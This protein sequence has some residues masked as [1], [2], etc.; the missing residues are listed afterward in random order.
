MSLYNI[1]SGWYTALTKE[2][3]I[4]QL[5]LSQQAHATLASYAAPM[6]EGVIKTPPE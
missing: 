3:F 1:L 4:V 6:V 5:G 2:R